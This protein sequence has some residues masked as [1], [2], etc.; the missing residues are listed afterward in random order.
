M[1]RSPWWSKTLRHKNKA[2]TIDI[3]GHLTRDA[4][5]DGVSATCAALDAADARAT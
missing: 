3:Y 2:T 1:C 4:A 5:A